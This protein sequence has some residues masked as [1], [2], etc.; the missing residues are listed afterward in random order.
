MKYLFFSIKVIV[1]LDKCACTQARF[2]ILQ[3]IATAYFVLRKSALIILSSLCQ[4]QNAGQVVNA[5]K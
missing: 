3:E 5:N 1:V 4:D 2:R